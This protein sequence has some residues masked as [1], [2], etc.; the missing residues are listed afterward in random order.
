MER[1]LRRGS[2]GDVWTVRVLGNK[3]SA[4]AYG[5]GLFVAV[6]DW[7]TILTSSDGVT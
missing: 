4:V 6:G 3:L 7:G 2:A 1:V 5:N